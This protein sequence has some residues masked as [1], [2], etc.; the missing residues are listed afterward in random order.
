LASFFR[1]RKE[2]GTEMGRTQ[3]RQQGD[4]L[5]AAPRPSGAASLE[6]A[7][8]PPRADAVRNREKLLTAAREA[9]AEDG[10][11]TS[12]EG[13]AARAGVGVGTLYRHFPKRVD[14]VEALY[15]EDIGELEAAAGRALDHNEPW[16]GLESCLQA[17]VRYS[18][19][20][21]TLLIELR[22]AFERFPE[23]R[24]QSRDRVMAALGPVLARAQAAGTARKDIGVDDLMQVLVSMCMSPTI[25]DAQAQ[26]LLMMILDGLRAPA[27]PPA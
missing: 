9:F 20:K 12:M 25:T 24:L 21:K 17:Y 15:K 10:S 7:A 27:P 18:L 11:E 14:I 1:R 19:R 13:I 23:L 26:R 8:R 2:T 5:P 4:G 6:P 16:A 22:E 3:V